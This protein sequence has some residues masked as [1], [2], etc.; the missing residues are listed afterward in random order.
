MSSPALEFGRDGKRWARFDRA[1]G[2]PVGYREFMNTNSIESGDRAIL[3]L[4]KF[5]R[6][7]GIHNSTAWRWR[8]RGWLK[9][10]NVG[11][12]QYIT[13]DGLAEFMR[14][15]EAGEFAKNMAPPA[16]RK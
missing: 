4:R 1:Q 6:D 11:G 16:R 5:T 3:S 12:R 13:R 9:T 10:V 2:T 14:R 15:A 7:A 8:H